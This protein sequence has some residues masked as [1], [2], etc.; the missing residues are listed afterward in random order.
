[1]GLK[2][3]AYPLRL[4]YPSSILGRLRAR[5]AGRPDSEHEQAFIRIL[6]VGLL[7]LYLVADGALTDKGHPEVRMSAYL[8]GA[9]FIVSLLYVAC[10]AIWP[11]ASPVRRLV[12]MVTDFGM[13]SAFMHFGGEAA[14]PFYAL[15]LWVALGNGF[16]YGLPYLAA[17]VSAAVCGF[18][19]VVLTTPFW[20]DN[21]T[22]G[23]GLLVALIVIPGYAASLIRNLTEAKA[24]AEAANRAK[25]RFL[26]TMSHELRTPLTA[27]IGTSDTLRET[28]LDGEQREMVETIN[29]SGG[30]LLALINDILDIARIEAN[31]V[32]TV[33]EPFDLHA[34]LAALATMLRPQAVAK[35]LRFAVHF[36]GDVPANIRGDRQHLKQILLNLISNAVKF[37]ERGYVLVAVSWLGDEEAG[38]VR[39]RFEV[40]DT[41]IGIDKGQQSRIFERFT[42]ADEHLHRQYEGSGLGLT[43]AKTLTELH[44]GSISV[45]SAIGQGS[46]FTMEIPFSVDRNDLLPV[47]NPVSRRI[48][49]LSADAGF[50]QRTLEALESLPASLSAATSADQAGDLIAEATGAAGDRVTV[51]IDSRESGI[52][53]ERVVEAVKAAAGVRSTD[54]SYLRIVE[55][56]TDPPWNVC[57]LGTVYAP[58]SARAVA[59]LLHAADAFAPSAA[60]RLAE[61]R[62]VPH[63]RRRDLTILL[64]EDNPINQKVTRRMLEYAGFGVALAGDGEEALDRLEEQSFDLMI[65]DVNMPGISGI[66]VIKMHRVA[67]LGDRRLPIIALSADATDDTRQACLEAGADTYLVKPVAAHILID[68]IETLVEVATEETAEQEP[69]AAAAEGVA[70]IADH[71]RYKSDIGRAIKWDVIET[72]QAYS[73]DDDFVAETLSEFVANSESLLTAIDAAVATGD[74]IAFRAHVHALRGT[75]GNVGAEGMANAC[76]QLR[77]MTADRLRAYGSE[78]VTRLRNELARFEAELRDHARRVRSPG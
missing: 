26:A 50:T 20:Q 69:A 57:T 8:S 38:S 44:G 51:L 24:N 16:R 62:L 5:F 68:T 14:A 65:V 40:I 41:G 47:L 52:S 31:K 3:V 59:T 37:T 19:M 55:E 63:E 70:R 77:G 76:E 23:L 27:I 71:P 35:G 12:A 7:F 74:P 4:G 45:H 72:L 34:E 10:I 29:T 25:T 9:Y 2:I 13:T 11:K 46:R 67:S 64:V 43:I 78:Y 17:S 33:C 22:L 28:S 60:D 54:I 36:S 48:C 58:V 18:F 6:L 56:K 73:G 42:Q 53:L 1:M 49:L 32:S 39:L 75:S 21:A 61:P 15:Y 66:D 30:A